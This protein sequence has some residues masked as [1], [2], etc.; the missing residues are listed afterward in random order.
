MA[1]DRMI[2]SLGIL[3][4]LQL[5][6]VPGLIIAKVF[7]IHGFWENLLAAIGLSQLFNYAFVVFA[8][9]LKIY[10]QSTVLI[11]LGIETIIVLVLYFPNLKWNLGKTFIPDGVMPFFHEYISKIKVKTEWKKQ[12]LTFIYF[13]AFAVAIICLT[14]YF[15]MYVAHPTQVFTKW[16][17]VVSWD[18]WATQWYQGI[19]PLQTEHYPQLWTANLSIPYQFIGT[20]DVKYFSKYFANLNE[21]SIVLVVFILGIKKRDIGYFFGVFFTSWLMASFGSQGSGYADSPVAFWGLMAIA[22]LVFAEDSEDERKLIILGA[23]FVSGAALTKQA[24][25][26]MVLVYPILI[27][28]RRSLKPKKSTALVI[29]SILIMI[30]LIAPWYIFK[31]IQIR[32]GIETSEIGR[33][34]SLVLDRHNFLQII[35]SAGGLFIDTLKNNYLPKTITSIILFVLL[36]FSYKDKL[37]GL[38]CRV[39]I[40]PFSIGWIFFFSYENRNLDLII[41]LLAIAAGVG[42]HNLL[43]LD[44]EKIRSFFQQKTPQSIT[45]FTVQLFKKIMKFIFSIKIW[46]FIILIPIIF[47]LPRWIPNNRLIQNSLIK[48]RNMG[49]PPIN[50]LLYDYMAKNGLD[51]KIITEYQYLGYLPELDKY[52]VYSLT[53]S[54]DFIDKFNSPEI[55]YALFNDHWW[56]EEVRDYVMK[57]VDEK[58]IQMIFTYPTPSGNGTFYF[59]T[60][61]HGVC[62]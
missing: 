1:G 2:I 13:L 26:W 14:R 45:Q 40:I 55:G 22:C 12:V 56:S 59:V 32:T 19:F 47:L 52:Y 35:G 8:T 54:P 37:W 51:G 61:C 48:Q 28:F 3:S 6:L 43:N 33:V 10:T 9:L 31:E 11:L 34:T 36:A 49:D 17:A 58:K 18:K 41:P 39:V 57:L 53:D 24:G 21:F 25:L 46:Y 30:I 27:V 4:L 16:D 5:T 42:L 50:Q 62:K 7:K 60:T 20:T 44:V 29:Q 38:I 23:F 15:F